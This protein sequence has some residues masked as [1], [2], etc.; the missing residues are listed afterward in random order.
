MSPVTRRAWLTQPA[1]FVPPRSTS[2]PRRII[3]CWPLLCNSFLGSGRRVSALRSGT[4]EEHVA[5]DHVYHGGAVSDV[6]ADAAVQAEGVASC[7]GA[8]GSVGCIW[9]NGTANTHVRKIAEARNEQ[10]KA[11]SAQ[12]ERLWVSRCR[13]RMTVDDLGVQR[14]AYAAAGCEFGK[15][16]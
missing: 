1:K 8:R 4:G 15:Y 2:V 3:D 7:G 6:G 14:Y 10:D 13:P 11:E 5:G 16:Q 9:R 12:R